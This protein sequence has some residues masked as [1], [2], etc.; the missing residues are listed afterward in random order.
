MTRPRIVTSLSICLETPFSIFRSARCNTSR[1]ST[2]GNSIINDF[3]HDCTTT[4]VRCLHVSPTY[5]FYPYLWLIGPSR[6]TWQ[7]LLRTLH[8]FSTFLFS[9][10][11]CPPPTPQMTRYDTTIHGGSRYW[12]PL[13]HLHTIMHTRFSSRT[14]IFWPD[15]SAYLP[16]LIFRC[17]AYIFSIFFSGSCLTHTV[18]RGVPSSSWPYIVEAAIQT[19][20]LAFAGA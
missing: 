13:F 4:A 6:M 7:N 12:L 18:S 15:S 3:C 1:A 16:F 9:R 19:R 8:F 17:I 20:F 11:P 10:L 5:F 14:P 2:P